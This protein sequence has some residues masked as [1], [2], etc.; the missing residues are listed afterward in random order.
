MN[1]RKGAEKR[2][3]KLSRE[4][5]HALENT[6]LVDVGGGVTQVCTPDVGGC[7]CNT[8]LTCSTALC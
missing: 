5:L 8:R 2:K 4:T 7:T 6:Q 3:L 1:K